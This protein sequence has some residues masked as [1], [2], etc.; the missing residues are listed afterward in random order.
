MIFALAEVLGLE[1]FGQAHDLGA[2]SGGI[3]DAAQGLLQILFRLR[4][5]G[6]L[7]QSHTEFFRGHAFRPPRTNIA[8]RLSAIC[9]VHLCVLWDDKKNPKPQRAQSFTEEDLR[10]ERIR[11]S[12]MLWPGEGWRRR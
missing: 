7:H 11:E 5:A 1:E 2:A 10:A 9:S 6:H 8:G 4:A 3:S 12:Q